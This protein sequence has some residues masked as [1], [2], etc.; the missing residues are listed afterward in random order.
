MTTA[1]PAGEEDC[2]TITNAEDKLMVEILKIQPPT[3][4]DESSMGCIWRN[5]GL[6]T[7]N[8]VLLEDNFRR[9]MNKEFRLYY[10]AEM[11][12][13]KANEVVDACKHVKGNNAGETSVNLVKCIGRWKMQSFI[14]SESKM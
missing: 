10:S 4:K 12:K 1:R 3:T 14:D 5:K 2:D 13:E 7:A 11:A 6:V 9:A 8:G